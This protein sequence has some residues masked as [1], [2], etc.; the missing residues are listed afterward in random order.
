[1]VFIPVSSVCPQSVIDGLKELG[2]IA[3]NQKYFFN[4]VNGINKENGCIEAVTDSRKMGQ[5]AG[6]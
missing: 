3:G 1:M 4:V 2:H 6:Y 5:S